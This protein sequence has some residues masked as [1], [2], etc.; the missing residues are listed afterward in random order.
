MVSVF[1]GRRRPLYFGKNSN[2]AAEKR[3]KFDKGQISKTNTRPVDRIV[4]YNFYKIT[5]AFRPKRLFG[6]ENRY[7]VKY[8]VG[9][10]LPSYL[11]TAAWFSTRTTAI[12]YNSEVNSSGDTL[13]RYLDGKI[14]STIKIWRK[15][16]WNIL[17]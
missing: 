8:R 3:E 1:K 10:L 12:W 15:D 9:T 7:R 6:D 11:A 4:K 14:R 13:T 5:N 17:H 16:N 2:F